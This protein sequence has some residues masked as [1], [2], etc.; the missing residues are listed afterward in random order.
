MYDNHI[1]ICT[2][3]IKS[4][5]LYLS[6]ELIFSLEILSVEVQIFAS[7]EYIILLMSHCYLGLHTSGINRRATDKYRCFDPTLLSR[8]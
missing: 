5:L 4:S 7:Y 3:S 6:F 1:S 8:S 2:L